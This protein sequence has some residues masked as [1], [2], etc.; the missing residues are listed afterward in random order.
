M[1][2]KLC[3]LFA[4]LICMFGFI[5]KIQAVSFSC[6]DSVTAGEDLKCDAIV[7]DSDAAI[8]ELKVSSSLTIRNVTGDNNSYSGKNATFKTSG[9]IVFVTDGLDGTY[10]IKAESGDK[11]YSN[12]VS[13]KINKATTK[14]TPSTT[15]TTKTTTKKASSNNLLSKILIDGEL[16]DDFDSGKTKYDYVVDYDTKK[17]SIKA[18]AEDEN[19]EVEV[20]NLDNL[21]VGDNLVT[22]TVTAEDGSVKYYK[23]TIEKKDKKASSNTKL[24]SIKVAGYKIDFDSSSKTFYLK[25]K[26]SDTELD[27]S[28]KAADKAAVVKINGNEELE[29]GSIIKIVVTAPDNT[30]STYRIIIEKEES[31]PLPIIIGSLIGLIVIGVA[32]F[33]IIQNKNN[34]K[35]NKKKLSSKSS[36][37][38]EKKTSSESDDD[39]DEEEESEEDDDDEMEKTIKMDKIDNDENEKTKTIHRETEEDLEKTKVIGE[40]YDED[41]DDYE[42]TF[43]I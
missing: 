21:D 32:V 5:T 26:P 24:K 37:S 29:D 41:Y 3:L 6:P 15:T 1:K 7:N 34:K 38:K 28:V 2:K 25:I 42:D 16:L 40:S 11:T 12:E 36:T 17:V 14:S 18:V 43:G 33:V 10:T 20:N 39:E 13:V 8:S 9:K 19:A 30:K 23:I 31:S 27:I 35:K 4:I 22:I